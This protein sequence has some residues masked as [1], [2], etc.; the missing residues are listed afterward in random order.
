MLASGFHVTV[1]INNRRG[2]APFPSLLE[3][4]FGVSHIGHP[5]RTKRDLSERHRRACELR[6]QGLSY[7]E[8]AQ[9]MGIGMVSDL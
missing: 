9:A 8:I 5:N 4:R 2:Q 1:A 7:P 6:A 3:A